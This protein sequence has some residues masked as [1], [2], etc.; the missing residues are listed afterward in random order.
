M[1]TFAIP[2]SMLD[3]P[4][5]A[6]QGVAEKPRTWLIVALLIVLGSVA[7]LAA[8]QT[9]QLALAAERTEQMLAALPEAQAEAVRQRPGG[10]VTTP[11][12]YWI[13][14]LVA[15]AMGAIGW[16]TRGT[17]IHF[18]SMALGGV[19]AWGSSFA[20]GVWSLLP[21]FVRDIV[22]VIY[23]AVNGK[24]I[25]HQGL[26]FLVA[27]GDMM[28]NARNLRYAA[29]AQLDPF[30]LWHLVLLTAGIAVATRMGRGRAFALALLITAAFIGTRLLPVLLTRSFMG[31]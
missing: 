13:G 31:G 18:G 27:S 20:V 24:V 26:S 15:I 22:Q 28:Q 19:S 11:Q 23:V 7:L 4:G 17:L 14:G 3:R 1:R 16:L 6:M 25:E 5:A 8:S 2:F 10:G 30:V 21:F 12:T 9:Q 29:L